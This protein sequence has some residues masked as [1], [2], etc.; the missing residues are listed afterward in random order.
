MPVS[1]VIGV[2]GIPA[3]GVCTAVAT[4][5]MTA[6]EAVNTIQSDVSL[7]LQTL[8]LKISS[9]PMEETIESDAK[10][11]N[12]NSEWLFR[13]PNEFLT[14]EF[15][16]MGPGVLVG[17]MALSLASS[18]SEY[19]QGERG[20]KAPLPPLEVSLRPRSHFFLSFLESNIYYCRYMLFQL[21]HAKVAIAVSL[22]V[23][24]VGGW[25]AKEGYLSELG[26][27]YM[28]ETLLVGLLSAPLG[29]IKALLEVPLAAGLGPLLSLPRPI[30]SAVSAYATGLMV[31][32]GL[33]K[34]FGL[35]QKV[36]D[37]TLG[38]LM[39]WIE[40]WIFN[41]LWTYCGYPAVSH[42]WK[43]R[44][45]NLVMML[46][47]YTITHMELEFNTVNPAPTFLSLS[48]IRILAWIVLGFALLTAWQA[49]FS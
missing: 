4:T 26:L 29:I 17:L 7:R 48:L 47:L 15:L 16:D 32:L 13:A 30:F 44:V 42:G 34:A 37:A 31:L 25:A 22:A 41:P 18:Q 2:K 11:K 28:L 10:A 12:D 1:V 46:F 43:G 20:L 39:S 6:L 8:K 14:Q 9:T 21:P 19:L 33:V 23:F 40:A 38:K 5:V 36:L 24:G 35:A 45:S 3:V 49:H 27:H